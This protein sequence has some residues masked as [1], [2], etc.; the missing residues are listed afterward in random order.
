[1]L[2]I[3]MATEPSGILAA[4]RMAQNLTVRPVSLTTYKMV[5]QPNALVGLGLPRIGTIMREGLSPFRSLGK[6]GSLLAQGVVA[7]SGRRLRVRRCASGHVAQITSP[8]IYASRA[9]LAVTET[10]SWL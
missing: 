6:D 10:S 7:F 8:R 2:M 9:G 3:S 1:M 4:S 5:A